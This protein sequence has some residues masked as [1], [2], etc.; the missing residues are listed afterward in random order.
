MSNG[1]DTTLVDRTWLRQPGVVVHTYNA[2]AATT[3]FKTSLSY[4]RQ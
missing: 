3:E 1:F 2:R 4:V